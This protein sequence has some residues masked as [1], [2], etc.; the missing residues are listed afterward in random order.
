MSAIK[1]GNIEAARVLIESGRVDIDA[2]NLDG[3]TALH[4]AAFKGEADLVKML[5]DAGAEPNIADL[6]YGTTPL[7]SAIKGGNIEA[8]RGVD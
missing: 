3:N 8:A 4:T 2:V 6:K 1:G 7:M 5:L